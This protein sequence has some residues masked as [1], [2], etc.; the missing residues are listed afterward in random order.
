MRNR[1]APIRCC[2]CWQRAAS[3]LIDSQLSFLCP[4]TS[5]VRA[6]HEAVAEL[7][8]RFP[9][10]GI[11]QFA[12]LAAIATR[13]AALFDRYLNAAQ[14]LGFVKPRRQFEPC[15]RSLSPHNTMW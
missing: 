9:R 8:Q 10:R 13:P 7:L 12:D 1:R 14:Q 15:R 3:R 2:V 11:A 5:M 6:C 4:T